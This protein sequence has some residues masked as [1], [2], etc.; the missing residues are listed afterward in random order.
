MSR[1]LFEAHEEGTMAVR[2]VT[3][4][5]SDLPQDVCDDLNIEV[6]PL[7][8]RFGDREYVD[9]KDLSTEA[10]GQELQR[11]SVLPETAPPPG[12]EFDEPFGT[13]AH[14]RAHALGLSAVSA[15]ACI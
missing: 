6:V 3:D 9:R 8:I 12:G 15:T 11:S 14:S 4:S 1:K 7:T 5:A 10:F 13:R 2:I